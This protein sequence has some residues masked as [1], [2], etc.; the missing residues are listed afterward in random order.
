MSIISR[1]VDKINLL[2]T[3]IE[4][5]LLSKFGFPKKSCAETRVYVELVYLGSTKKSIL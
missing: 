4:S 5:Y 3:N 2:I 1:L